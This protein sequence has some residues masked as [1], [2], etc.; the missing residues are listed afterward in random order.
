[1]VG[2]GLRSAA[3]GDS[4]ARVVVVA[5]RKQTRTSGF[6]GGLISH[7]ECMPVDSGRRAVSHRPRKLDDPCTRLYEE[8]DDDVGVENHYLS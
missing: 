2:A 7:V 1:M 5:L 3:R 4:A 6:R 8:N